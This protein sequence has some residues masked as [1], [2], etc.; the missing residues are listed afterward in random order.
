MPRQARH[1]SGV[2]N[3]FQTGLQVRQHYERLKKFA[4]LFVQTPYRSC[5]HY[6]VCYRNHVYCH[7][8]LDPASDCTVMN[9]FKTP[10]LSCHAVAALF[11]ACG[12]Y[13]QPGVFGRCVFAVATCCAERRRSIND[14][15]YRIFSGARRF[16]PACQSFL[17]AHAA[18]QKTGAHNR[19]A[20]AGLHQ[21]RFSAAANSF[22]LIFS[23]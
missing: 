4:V 23:A 17:F 1:G 9:F 22:C 18:S 6:A 3:C 13:L 11:F 19:S 10:Y 7:A 20:L 2:D 5:S 8:G 12:V 14:T 21:F 16:Q 15:R